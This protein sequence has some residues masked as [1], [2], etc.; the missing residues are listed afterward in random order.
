VNATYIGKKLV[1]KFG[2]LKKEFQNFDVDTR[3][4]H[5]GKH[6]IRLVVGQNFFAKLA[7]QTF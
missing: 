3:V 4:G 5:Y 7:L 1:L 2:F 6:T